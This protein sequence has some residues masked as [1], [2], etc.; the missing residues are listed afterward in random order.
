VLTIPTVLALLHP[1]FFGA[2]D[3][4]HSAWIYEMD[5]VLKS[6]IF[7]PRFVPDLSFGFGYPLF[8]FIYPFP[9]YLGELFHLIG[10]SLVNSTK[11]VLFLS[12]PV[13]AVTMFLF[14]KRF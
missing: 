9:Y 10:L 12:I 5:R 2:S 13:S 4:M 7:P 3:D 6:G 11:A 1:G 8:N 14:L